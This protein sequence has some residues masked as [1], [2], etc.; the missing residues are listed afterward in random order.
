MSRVWKL[1][2]SQLLYYADPPT[3]SNDK[4]T[5]IVADT[6][7]ARFNKKTVGDLVYESEF[8]EILKPHKITPSINTIIIKSNGYTLIFRKTDK[9]TAFNTKKKRAVKSKSRRKSRS[10]RRKV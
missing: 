2:F 4:E 5:T 9:R 8:S 1:V 6:T 7:D 10:S 3:S